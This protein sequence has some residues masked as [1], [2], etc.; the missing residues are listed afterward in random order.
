VVFS[1][2]SRDVAE[3]LAAPLSFG[4]RVVGAFRE[5]VSKFEL[6][7][8]KSLSQRERGRVAAGEG[9]RK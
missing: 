9:Y 1:G 6:R 8:K 3:S 2:A 4:L 5:D 7:I